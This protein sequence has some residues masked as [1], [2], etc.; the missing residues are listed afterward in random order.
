MKE[1]LASD[2][3]QLAYRLVGS[4]KT[5]V[6]LVHG[7]MVS[8]AV[9]DEFASALTDCTLLIPDLRGTG[10]SSSAATYSI[11]Q[12]ASDVMGAVD[13]AGF[14]DFVLLGHSMG[15]QI[16]Q[17]VAATWPTRVSGL[18]LLNSVP[19]GGIPLPDEAV[20]LFRH[21]AGSR[22]SQ[23]TILQMACK[24]LSDESK[25]KL[26]D[27]A[28]T[29]G[30]DCIQGAFDAWTAG[31]FADKLGAITAPTLVVAT[32][33][34]F[35]PPDFLTQAVVEPIP[36]ARLTYLAGPGHYPQVERTSDTAALFHSFLAGLNQ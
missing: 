16:A 25:D 15:G 23:G 9:F 34:P 28:G 33:D 19:A 20:Q 11:E 13:D 4:G 8:G 30:E 17:W 10:S 32:D 7:W 31:G 18:M 3:T 24:Q 6:V 22:E 29:I 5:R 35:L 21:S 14:D 1:Y 12:Y 2:Q 26:L 36:N 27:D